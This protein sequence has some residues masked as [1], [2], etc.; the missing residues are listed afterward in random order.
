MGAEYGILGPLTV[1]V[2][3]VD[4]TPS[5][6]KERS[7]LALLVV[8]V[9]RVVP[10][11]RLIDELWPDAEPRRARRTLQVRVAAVRKLLQA[12]GLS[13]TLVFEGGGY[14]LAAASEQIDA[15]R[16]VALVERAALEMARSHPNAAATTLREALGLWR[17]DPLS[18]VEMSLS[19]EAEAARLRDARIGAIE[20]R[21]DAEMACGRHAAAVAEL[22]GL[23]ALHPFRERLWS[24]R[25]LALYRCG[26]QAEALR[27]FDS[28]RRLL[29]TEL[30]VEP[31]AALRDLHQ[32]VLE[33]RPELDWVTA[34]VPGLVVPPG[35]RADLHERSEALATLGQAQAAVTR[36]SSGRVILVGGEA[37]VGKT[38]LLRTFCSTLDAETRVLWGSCDALFTPRPLG[39]LLDI[40]PYTDGDLGELLTTSATP[41]DVVVAFVAELQLRGPSVV[42][43]EDIHWADEATLDVL[44][45]LAR[46]AGTI[47]ALVLASYRNDEFDRDDPVR[48]VLGELVR[49]ECVNRLTLA[50]LSPAGVAELAARHH[51]DASELYRKTMGNPF[52]VTEVL[53]GEGDI[54]DTVRDA[55]LAHAARL[56]PPA[57]SLLDATA[58]ASAVIEPWLLDALAGELVDHLEECLSSGMLT[59]EADGVA[60]R[61]ELARLAIVDEI[62][63]HRRLA[64]HRRIVSALAAPPSGPSDLA[65]LAHHAQAAG[66]PAGVLQFAPAA[67]EQAASLGAHRE[68]AIL[69]ASALRVA[70]DEPLAM[71]ADLFER[72]SHEC[73][74]TDQSDEAMEAREQALECY[75]RLGDRVKEGDSLR[76]LSRLRWCRGRIAECDDLGRQAVAVL[77]E[78]SEGPELAMAYSNVASSLA[79]S[80]DTDGAIAWGTRAL[81]LGR[82][83]DDTE[84]VVHAL[85][86]LGLAAFLADGPLGR[87]QLEQSLRLA[88]EAGLEEHAGRAL[89]HLCWAATR[90]RAHDTFDHI[91]PIALEYCGEHGLDLHRAYVHVYGARSDLDRGRWDD[92]VAGAEAIVAE[93]RPSTL[94][95]TLGLVVLATVR[96]RRGEPGYRQLLDEARELADPTGEMQWIAPVAAA[97]A[98]A[99]WLEG[100]H[101]GV[102]AAT[103]A[104][105]RLAVDRRASWLIG[106]LAYWRSLAAIRDELPSMS[107]PYGLALAGHPERAAQR[108]A[109]LG[110]PYEH[111]LITTSIGGGD[112]RVLALAELDRLGARAVSMRLDLRPGSPA[113]AA[114]RNR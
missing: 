94:P 102:A 104:A 75:Q 83:L 65:R 38:A 84:V 73:F 22:D 91:R 25:I 45:L 78:C 100:D 56:S 58:V 20:A 92:A 111:A 44:R 87:A 89:V 13:A 3:D 41:Y 86:S 113:V 96:V 90:H 101:D 17:G 57:R 97:R 43:F 53:A 71:R 63:P 110:C 50:P 40:A 19:L 114:S 69:Y 24:Q 82:R 39:P 21:I 27:G 54:P 88:Q 35:W 11:D 14:R 32:A 81:E 62:A 2:D 55:V 8:S 70:D 31:N 37:G 60:F 1:V 7:L 42:V 33:Q 29:A 77:E 85:N 52:F 112:A 99:A 46:R 64:L 76:W 66:D 49:Q 12:C 93:Q 26:R 74:V 107:N 105:L 95:R 5:A 106:E 48:I 68:A 80:E 28:V 103:D 10:A 16:F 6:A 47:P 15:N 4:V 79:N 30:G 18:D 67:A 109:E 59:R 51:V 72:R 34:P 36:G 108:W 98:E 9:G 61:H 23:L